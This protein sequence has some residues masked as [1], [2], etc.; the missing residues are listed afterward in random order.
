MKDII[1]QMIVEGAPVAEI[2]AWAMASGAIKGNVQASTE[3]RKA[4][5]T[6]QAGIIEPELTD[7]QR[8]AR[9]MTLLDSARARRKK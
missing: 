5:E 4:T 6:G 2:I 7:E 9:I 8:A 3:L 1:A